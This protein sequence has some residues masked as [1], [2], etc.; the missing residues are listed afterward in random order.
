MFCS[1]LVPGHEVPP[2]LTVGAL[3]DGTLIVC[4]L[5]DGALIDGTL[6]D[7]SL[8][9]GTRVAVQTTCFVGWFCPASPRWHAAL[10][11]GPADVG[12]LVV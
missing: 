5:I 6:T 10:V 12:D 2:A 7:G 3:T 1:R 11:T 9:D 4:A 8:I